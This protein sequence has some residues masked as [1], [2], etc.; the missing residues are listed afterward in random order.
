MSEGNGSYQYV[1]NGALP[2]ATYSIFVIDGD[3]AEFECDAEVTK[4]SLTVKQ[5]IDRNFHVV[6]QYFY[7]VDNLK[8]EVLYAVINE[9]I[10]KKISCDFFDF[11]LDSYSEQRLFSYRVELKDFPCVIYYS[12]PAE[13]QT[14]ST[15]K[16]ETYLAEQIATSNYAVN[17]TIELNSAIPYIIESSADLKK[18]DTYVYSALNISDDF[19][20]VFSSSK[21]P[22]N[23]YE[24]GKNSA[25]DIVL[26]VILGVSVCTLIVFGI[27]MIVYFIKR[28]KR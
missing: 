19:Y 1:F 27:V 5:Y 9:I 16:P 17:Y 6:K 15:F 4:E 18:Q 8:P 20:F 25:L 23:I 13:V 22:K 11:F 28:R 3:F 26:Y 21:K 24:N 7:A 12:M 10:D 14:N 2:A